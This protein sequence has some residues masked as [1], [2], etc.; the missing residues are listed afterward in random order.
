MNWSK[1]WGDPKVDL[2]WS[3][4]HDK[5]WGDTIITN[6]GDGKTYSEVLREHNKRGEDLIKAA[7]QMLAQPNTV[8]VPTEE[9]ELSIPINGGWDKVTVKALKIGDLAIIISGDPEE[10]LVVHV[11][12]LT[13]F[14]NAIPDGEWTQEQL[15]LWVQKVQQ[16]KELFGLISQYDNSDY[17]AIPKNILEMLKEHCLSV[18]IK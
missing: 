6:A 17:K 14:D 11:P 8:A 5:S 16:E 15:I 13:W 10:H 1:S 9:I 7:S 18:N 2:S 12:T 3:D 4:D